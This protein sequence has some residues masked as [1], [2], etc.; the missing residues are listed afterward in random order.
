MIRNTGSA[1]KVYHLGIVYANAGRLSN[2]VLLSSIATSTKGENG[3]IAVKIG[4]N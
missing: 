4:E 3:I 1:S 2:G